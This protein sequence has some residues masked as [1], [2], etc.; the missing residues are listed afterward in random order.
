MIEKWKK[1]LDKGF[2]LQL[3]GLIFRNRILFLV[4][5]LEDLIKLR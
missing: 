3:T 2:D 4:T 5:F 1:V